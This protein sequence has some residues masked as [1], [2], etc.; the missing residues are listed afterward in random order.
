MLTFAFFS[1]KRVTRGQARQFP[2]AMQLPVHSSSGQI[3]LENTLRWSIDVVLKNRLSPVP[4]F[5]IHN[6]R[7]IWIIMSYF[8]FIKGIEQLWMT[9]TCTIV[10]SDRLYLNNYIA[11]LKFVSFTARLPQVLPKSVWNVRFLSNSQPFS[12]TAPSKT[13]SMFAFLTAASA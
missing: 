11:C 10:A 12:L 1:V 7:L 5:P 3:G 8:A 4:K 13:C 2:S 9:V 6:I